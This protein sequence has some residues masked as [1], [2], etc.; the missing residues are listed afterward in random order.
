MCLSDRNVW[1]QWT[2]T[3]SKKKSAARLIKDKSLKRLFPSDSKVKQ[4]AEWRQWSPRCHLKTGAIYYRHH[5][6]LRLG[7]GVQPSMPGHEKCHPFIR[8][9][10]SVCSSENFG[11][12]GLQQC[13]KRRANAARTLASTLTTCWPS[14]SWASTSWRTYWT[15]M[16]TTIATTTIITRIQQ[17]WTRQALFSQCQSMSSSLVKIQAFFSLREKK[18]SRRN[19][20]NSGKILAKNSRIL[21]KKLK[22]I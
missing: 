1:V 18:Y 2:V 19:V 13:L 10:G 6:K 15:Q 3:I 9:K 12:C 17:L 4:C 14:A 11:R 20:K 21:S 22:Q 16:T 8:P 7:I 5:S